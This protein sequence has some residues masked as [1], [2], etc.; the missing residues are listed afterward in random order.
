[1]RRVIIDTDPGVDDVLAILMLM[2]SPDISIEAITTVAG[3][4]TVEAA[5]RNAV[6]VTDWA[7][8]QTE[9]VAGSPK[10]LSRLLELATIH[11]ED[12]LSGLSSSLQ[13]VD[14]SDLAVKKLLE[15][16]NKYPH[17]IELLAIGPLTNVARAIQVDSETM[18]TL[19]SLVVLGGAL[20]VGGNTNQ[21]A[22]FNFY[23]DP[24]AAK[25]VLSSK[26]PI[27]MVPLDRCYEAVVPMDIFEKLPSQLKNFCQSLL[28]PYMLRQQKE[29]GVSGL[30]IYD[31]LAAGVLSC[32]EMGCYQSLSLSVNTT[33]DDQR[34]ALIFDNSGRSKIRVMKTVDVT[35]FTKIVQARLASLD[36]FRY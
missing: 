22:E 26:L 30:V 21:V 28:R 36:S 35:W 8:Y 12:G 7:D 6:A 5:T 20:E 16:V 10:P 14:Y 31:A 1:M 15:L 17:E 23:T 24:E 2:S 33:D 3:N 19:K 29:E 4:V 34:G 25:I 11:G 27:T 9:V 13:S 32:P 18:S